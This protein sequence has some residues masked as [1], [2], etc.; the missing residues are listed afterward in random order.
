MSLAA[1]CDIFLREE[2]E[3][4]NFDADSI[5]WI[6]QGRPHA[7]FR[8]GTHAVFWGAIT[9]AWIDHRPALHSLGFDFRSWVRK[10]S[11]VYQQFIAR[12]DL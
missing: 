7:L 10:N 1:M 6:D 3:H 9:A 12:R 2:T 4:L 8:L 11:Q 5:V